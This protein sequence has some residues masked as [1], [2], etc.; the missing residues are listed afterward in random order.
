MKIIGALFIKMATNKNNNKDKKCANLEKLYYLEL[1]LT[2]ILIERQ[3]DAK[4]RHKG[5][6]G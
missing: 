2:N 5:K 1:H 4:G 3:I 6:G